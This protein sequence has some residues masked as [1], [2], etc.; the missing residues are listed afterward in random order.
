MTAPPE[1]LYWY[2]VPCIT[3]V[4]GDT[5]DVLTDLGFRIGW[6]QRSAST[7]STRTS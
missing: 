6:E 1:F 2:R 3:V 7:W 4:V 5:I